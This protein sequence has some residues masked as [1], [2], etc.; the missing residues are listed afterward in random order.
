[1]LVVA[2]I[3][4]GYRRVWQEKTVSM[5]HLQGQSEISK[6]PPVQSCLVSIPERFWQMVKMAFINLHHAPGSCHRNHPA[7][8]T[9]SIQ[10][11]LSP[12]GTD[13]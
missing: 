1:M 5:L 12:E 2:L 3:Y 13:E 9:I 10:I 11:P 8:I 4:I 7:Y 6:G